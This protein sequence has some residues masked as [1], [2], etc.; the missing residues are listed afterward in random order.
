MGAPKIP[1]S[2]KAVFDT[3]PTEL[4]PAAKSLRKLIFETAVAENA[5]PLTETLKWGEPAYLTE[6]S[7]SGTT[8]RI[9]WKPKEPDRIKLLVNCRT[10]LLEQYRTHYADRLALEGNRAIVLKPDDD[11]SDPALAHC[12]A[13]ALTYHRKSTG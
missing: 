12:I 3:C 4:R 1:D 9:G 13:L 8:L 11:F 2:V 5:G 6:A 7:K 10:T